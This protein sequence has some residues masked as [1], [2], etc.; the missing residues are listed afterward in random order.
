MAKVLAGITMGAPQV[1]QS[2]FATFI[3]YR[4]KK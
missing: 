4:V 3:N 2:P 1:C